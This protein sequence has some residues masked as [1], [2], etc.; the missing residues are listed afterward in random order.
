MICVSYN[1]ETGEIGAVVTYPLADYE[2]RYPGWLYLGNTAL[3]NANFH[4]V[5]DGKVVDRPVQPIE[6]EN[7][8]LRG[9]AKGSNISIEDRTYIADGTDIEL[10]F[11]H[12]GLFTIVIT[13][14]PFQET[15]VY[16]HET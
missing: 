13:L 11:G 14:F 6:L 15:R 5:V 10:S 2:E 12:T 16:H 7:G 8:V 3:V 1:K 9:V 4:Y